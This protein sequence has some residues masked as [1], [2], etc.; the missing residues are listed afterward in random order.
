MMIVTMRSLPTNLVKLM[1][2]DSNFLNIKARIVTSG[3]LIKLNKCELLRNI[4]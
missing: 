2:Y 3:Y 1:N 4:I